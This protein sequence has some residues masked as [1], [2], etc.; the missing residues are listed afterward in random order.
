MIV[1]GDADLCSNQWLKPSLLHK[2]VANLLIGTLESC[3][4]TIIPVGPT[5]IVDHCTQNGSIA[6]SWLDHVYHNE[7]LKTEINTKIINFGSSDHLPVIVCQKT[8]LKRKVYKRKIVKRKMKNFTNEKW[9]EVLKNED[10]SE[11]YESNDLD[12]KV[13][14]FTK[15]VTE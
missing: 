11:I 1:M 5:F 10:W 7:S 12:N 9:N 14:T 4:L 15:L 3:G 13:R 2:N 6:E 8:K